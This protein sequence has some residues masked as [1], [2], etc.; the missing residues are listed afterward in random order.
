MEHLICNGGQDRPFPLRGTMS[1][2]RQ[3][4]G[5]DHSRSGEVQSAAR[6]ADTGTLHSYG[7]A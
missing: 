7:R 1:E 4:A 3:L 5:T 6:A 2:A